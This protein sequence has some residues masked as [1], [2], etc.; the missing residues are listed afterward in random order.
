MPDLDPTQNAY[1]INNSRNQQKIAKQFDS[2]M[3]FKQIQL[4]LEISI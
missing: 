4:T 1:W 2:E 3:C